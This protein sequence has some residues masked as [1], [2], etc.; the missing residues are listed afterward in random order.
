MM[1][2]AVVG[3][4]GLLMVPHVVGAKLPLSNRAL[5]MLIV[6]ASL[7]LLV[8]TSGQISLCHTAFAALGATTLSHLTTGQ[9]LPWGLALLL[10]G[11]TVAPLGAL[12][13]IPAIRLSGVYLALATFG[14]AILMQTVVYNTG[15]MFGTLRFRK[16]ARPSLG[17]FD[18][19]ND[20]RY[21][22]LVL[23]IAVASCLILA[24][25]NRGRLGRLLRAMSETATMLFYPWSPG[26]DHAPDRL[27]H[28]G[29]LRGHRWRPDRHAG[30]G[31]QFGQ[32]RPRPVAV[33]AHR[34]RH[35]RHSP[36]GSIGAGHD[37]VRVDAGVCI[38]LR[39]GGAVPLLRPARHCGHHRRGQHAETDGAGTA[40]GLRSAAAAG[41]TSPVSDRRRQLQER[42]V[43]RPAEDVRA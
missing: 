20:V 33:V 22:Y 21:Y 37:P 16:V 9:G 31:R 28:L 6:F 26:Q 42:S 29:I 4:L 5:T 18:G 35:L 8:F 11:L 19:R 13:A 2:V 36:P 38:G 7:A 25:I 1:S 32:L 24:A 3:G 17:F 10:A 14:F 39:V 41:L 34:P 12:V 30:L 43:L 15:F 27:L 23:A 40:S